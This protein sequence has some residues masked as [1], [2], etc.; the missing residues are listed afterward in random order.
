MTKYK[1]ITI[2]IT[3]TQYRAIKKL[4]KAKGDNPLSYIIREALQEY[5]NK[6]QE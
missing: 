2:K 3:Q 5:I 4:A 1:Q 6:Y